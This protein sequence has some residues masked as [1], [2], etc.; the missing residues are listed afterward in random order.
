MND[1]EADVALEY[2]I[3]MIQN[4]Q[5]NEQ[6]FEY[7]GGDGNII[8]SLDGSSFESS[9]SI[10]QSSQRKGMTDL[11]QVDQRIILKAWYEQF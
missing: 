9:D 5:L 8:E 3:K 4:N 2:C 1:T 11:G 7:Q 6:D 10:E